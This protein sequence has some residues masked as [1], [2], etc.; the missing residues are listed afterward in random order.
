MNRQLQ[1]ACPFYEPRLMVT[2]A[3]IIAR[4]AREAKVVTYPGRA[5]REGTHAF[6]QLFAAASGRINLHCAQVFDC[7]IEKGNVGWR[8]PCRLEVEDGII[9]NPRLRS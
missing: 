2:V 4:A 6:G 3:R 1:S 9:T 5:S 8:W 7:H